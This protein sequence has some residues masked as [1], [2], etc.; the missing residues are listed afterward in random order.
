MQ[1]RCCRLLAGKPLPPFAVQFA[2]AA[3]QAAYWYRQQTASGKIPCPDCGIPCAANARML[4][5][6]LNIGRNAG[7]SSQESHTI[8]AAAH[9]GKYRCTKLPICPSERSTAAGKRSASDGM[10]RLMTRSPSP[11]QSSHSKSPSRNRLMH[12][13]RQVH[14]PLSKANLP[15]IS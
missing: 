3:A 1:L 13:C 12:S 10:C 9:C 5:D 11:V 6:W 2:R 15:L 8:G 4:E 7:D 14:H